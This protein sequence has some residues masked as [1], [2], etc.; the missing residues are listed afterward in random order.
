MLKAFLSESTEGLTPNTWWS[1]KFAGHNKEATLELKKLF[2]GSS[3][4][5]TPKPTRLI[6]RILDL[7]TEQDSVILDSFAGSGTT[8]HAVL[9]ANKADKGRRKFV[10]V[11]QRHDTKDEEREDLNVCRQVTRERVRRAIDGGSEVQ[12]LGGSFTYARVGDP[13]FGEYRDFG[14]RLPSFDTLA[15]YVFYTETSRQADPA[16]FDPQTGFIGETAAG[17][18][19]SYYLL[20]T[21]DPEASRELS[22]VTLREMLGRDPRPNWVVYCEKFWMHRDQL[23]AFEAEHGK[24]IRAM[25]V[26]FNLK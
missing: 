1:Y 22:L 17:G 8:A 23:A 25:I 15:S 3:P 16:K 18:G 5:D 21:P 9:E 24:R 13:L 6:R 19:T 26:P 2:D 14:E 11:Q 7:F 10:L 12:G 4:F 20:Y